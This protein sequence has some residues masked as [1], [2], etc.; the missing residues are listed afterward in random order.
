MAQKLV[1]CECNIG[2]DILQSHPLA[3]II[4]DG[5]EVTSVS[6]YSTRDNRHMSLVLLSEPAAT[7][8]S[9]DNTEEQG[10]GN[11]EGGSTEQ[12]SDNTEQGDGE[13][14]TEP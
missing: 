6:G 8:T 4:A 12:G 14:T 2:T 11:S 9:E 1:L 10:S 13:T 3:D 7:S 5:Y